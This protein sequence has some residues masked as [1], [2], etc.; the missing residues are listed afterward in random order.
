MTVPS[1]PATDILT[2]VAEVAAG[3]QHACAVTQTGGIRCWG[4]NDHGQVDRTTT[5]WLRSPPSTDL[6]TGMKAVTAASTHSCALS[7]L[8]GVRCWGSA[9]GVGYRRSP[10]TVVVCP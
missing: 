3:E 8:G 10:T 9:T 2:N 1:P 4:L 6:F 5:A 7:N